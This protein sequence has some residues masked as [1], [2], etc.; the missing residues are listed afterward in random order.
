MADLDVILGIVEDIKEQMDEVDKKCDQLL[1]FR[2]VHTEV[3]KIIDSRQADFKKTLY[4]GGD[5]GGGLTYKVDRLL[6]FSKT[7]DKWSGF[8]IALLRTLATAAIIGVTAFLLA[9]YRYRGPE[10]PLPDSSQPVAVQPS[11]RGH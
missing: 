8:W 4:G 11:S 9:V 1:E 6:Q 7:A 3:H 10:K 5:N 2:A